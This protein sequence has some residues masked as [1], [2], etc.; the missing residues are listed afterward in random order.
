MKRKNF[1][2]NA[3]FTSIISLLLCISMLAGTTFAWFTDSVSSGINT[4]AAGVLDVELY[5]SNAAVTEQKVDSATQLFMDLNGKPILWEPGVVSF[6]NLRVANEGDLALAY[7]LAIQ[8]ANENYIVDPAGT[9]Y[10]LSQILKVGVV[11]GGITATTRE[12][13]VA[14]V[15]DTEWTTLAAFLRSGALPAAGQET[16]GIVVYW[17]PGENDNNW[18]LNNGK[19]LSSGEVLQIDLGVKLVATQE[20]GEADSFG[21]DY[22]ANA[23]AEFF[24]GFQGGTAAAAI[25]ADDQGVTSAE[26]QMAGGDVSA[27][28]PAGVQVAEGVNTL[29]LTVARK[30]ASEANIQLSASEE[31][32]PLDVH[33]EGVAQGNTVPMLITLK[34]YLSTGINTG[35]LR[36]YHVENGAPVEMTQ[37]AEPKNHNE[38]SYDP[39][40]GDLTLAMASFSEV[41]TIADTNNTWD[42]TA[43]T[44]FAGGTG[45]EA[46]P[47]Q[48]ANADQLAYFRNQ[49]D[50][51]NTFA[52]K[53]VKL[54]NNIT[55]SNV[56]F[57]PIGWGYVNTEWNSG[58]AA[59][60]VFQGT[61]DGNKKTISGLYQNGWDLEAANGTDYTYTNCGF[62]L[63][64]AASGATF[65]DLA[66]YGA[67][68]KTECVEMGVLVGL[69]QN[70]CKYDNINIV[71]SKIA[72]YQRPAG[73]LIGEVSGDGTTTITNVKIGSDVVV[74][75]LW[76]DFDGPCGGVIGARWDD[77]GKDPQIVMKDVT[78][79]ARM[80]VYND[81]TSAYQWHAYRRAGMLIGNT[82]TSTKNEKGTNIATAEFLSCENVKAYLGSWAD[83][84]YCEF[85]N[86]QNPGR[87]YPWV[88]VQA[89]E[90]NP[91]YSNPRYG[92][93]KDING[94]PVTDTHDKNIHLTGNGHELVRNFG[95]LY[96]G[97]QGVYGATMHPGAELIN[98]RYTITYMHGDEVLELVYVTQD[99]VISTK[100]NEAQARVE[101]WAKEEFGVGNFVLGGWMNAGSTKLE[102]IP[103]DN[104][105][106]IVLYPYFDEPYTASFVDLQGNVLSQCYFF[107]KEKL[108]D[109]DATKAAAESQLPEADP[110]TTLSHWEVHYDGKAETFNKDNFASYTKSVT[111]YPVYTYDGK[112]NLVPHDTDGDGMTD[113]YSVES[114]SGLSGDVVVPGSINGIKVTIITDLSSDW[115]NTQVTSIE[116][117]EGVEEI[118]SNAF[119][120]TSG[121]KEVS[122]PTS[123]TSIGS[124]AFASTVGGALIQKKLTITYA[125]TWEQFEEACATNWER[126]L[127]D[128][129]KVICSNGTATLSTR[130]LL[131]YGDYDWSFVPNA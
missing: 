110:D 6:E 34:H 24:P 63:F 93:P 23:K 48:I 25:T 35:A 82:E 2:R 116:I 49:V 9:Q 46:D 30:A 87:N 5:H 53:T 56:N 130:T 43:A 112:L 45:T 96:G 127:A 102:N 115:L 92:H 42:G 128:G 26:A 68:I 81:I 66:I 64:A 20:L 17:Q 69:S 106:D 83:Y 58:G 65:K 32:Q 70:T 118:K 28:V 44:A 55:L 61:F 129:T 39:A 89:G 77:A 97:G 120:M 100:N 79:A 121:L 13:V 76:G 14:S 22:D 119:A 12:E 99:G 7:Q 41:A 4:I 124:N 60:K 80:D 51:G 109:L 131:G 113:Y 54:E 88:R 18:N 111:V 85:S 84:T 123:V 125:G 101:A 105:K 57:D 8:T 126:G 1:T 75:T 29:G 74:G 16:W 107:E 71:N 108:G 36:L 40:T 10:G 11:P 95:Q 73:G 114:A 19:Q 104:D 15:T 38:F 91:A 62:G 78:V 103:A 86:E 47:Y 90:N 37:V 31:L 122:I 52:G 27:V 67:D 21:N 33:M 50:G 94:N 72:N 3:L 117:R 98:L 59:G